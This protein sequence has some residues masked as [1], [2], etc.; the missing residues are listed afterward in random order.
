[1]DVL[2]ILC[3]SSNSSNT[4]SNRVTSVMCTL[5]QSRMR[6][7]S[8]SAHAV[9]A[10]SSLVD[11]RLAASI[12]FDTQSVDGVHDVFFFL[13]ASRS[14]CSRHMGFTDTSIG[15]SIT[16]ICA[17]SLTTLSKHYGLC[18]SLSSFLDKTFSV[19]LNHCLFDNIHQSDVTSKRRVRA[20]SLFC[21]DTSCETY[22]ISHWYISELHN[23]SFDRVDVASM[24]HFTTAVE[25]AAGIVQRCPTR[26]YPVLLPN[27][28][29]PLDGIIT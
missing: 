28:E 8:R 13:F 19:L 7:R 4:C 9:M 3:P 20:R 15:G 17:M 5:L 23:N 18:N 1:M 12:S 26:L 21:T 11:A 24:S 10:L 29:Q 14:G 2:T 27:Y 22:I 6:S 16:S 25:A